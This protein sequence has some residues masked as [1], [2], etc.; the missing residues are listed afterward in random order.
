MLYYVPVRLSRDESLN[1]AEIKIDK[2]S[3]F[4]LTNQNAMIYYI[5]FCASSVDG[6]GE[7]ELIE[8]MIRSMKKI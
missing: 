8:T 5:S 7:T 6:D 1:G 4:G 3:N 2:I